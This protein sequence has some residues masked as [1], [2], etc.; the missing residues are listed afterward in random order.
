[1]GIIFSEAIFHRLNSFL[2]P[3]T[4]SAGQLSTTVGI[5]KSNYIST[6]ISTKSISGICNFNFLYYKI[7]FHKIFN[8]QNNNLLSKLARIT[9]FECLRPIAIAWNNFRAIVRFFIEFSIFLE[10]ISQQRASQLSCSAKF[11]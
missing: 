8:F 9:H 1:M 11:Y 5:Y 6:I 10:C 4:P 2:A 3:A 7:T